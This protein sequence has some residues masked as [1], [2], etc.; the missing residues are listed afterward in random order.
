MFLKLFTW[1]QVDLDH[2]VL[3]V[4]HIH[5][6]NKFICSLVQTA[7]MNILVHVLLFPQRSVLPV[8][9]ESCRVHPHGVLLKLSDCFPKWLYEYNV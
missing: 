2:S 3:T 6:I 1:L 9:P 5:I 4:F 7:K 8:T